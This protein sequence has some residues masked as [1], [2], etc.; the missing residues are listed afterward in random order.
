MNWSSYQELIVLFSGDLNWRI[1][2]ELLLAEF[3]EDRG[4]LQALDSRTLSIFNQ[5]RDFQKCMRHRTMKLGFNHLSFPL[6]PHLFLCQQ[7]NQWI[8]CT[9]Q[10]DYSFQQDRELSIK[11]VISAQ[12]KVSPF[13]SS[14]SCLFLS[15]LLTNK[16]KH[17]QY[18]LF[19][20]QNAHPEE[21]KCRLQD[22]TQKHYCLCI[23]K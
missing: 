17:F 11:W 13:E 3:E 4:P 7:S 21:S 20:L 23:M 16:A 1:L 19:F 6:H 10:D 22:R 2:L 18:L 5:K 9:L 8:R 14:L 15:L 12:T